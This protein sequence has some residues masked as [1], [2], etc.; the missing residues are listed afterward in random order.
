MADPLTA[1]EFRAIGERIKRDR[2]RPVNVNI[3]AEVDRARLH[4]ALERLIDSGNRMYQANG[5]WCV[6]FSRGGCLFKFD[7]KDAAIDALLGSE[8]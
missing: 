4:A 3:D 6:Y 8:E 1:A 2:L 7:T 5:K